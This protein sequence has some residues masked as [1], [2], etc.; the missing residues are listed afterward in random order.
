M[1]RTLLIPISHPDPE[2][3][4]IPSRPDPLASS[5]QEATKL[6]SVLDHFS[7]EALKLAERECVTDQRAL[8]DVEKMYLVST[9]RWSRHL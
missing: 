4:D 7:D 3:C 1:L 8:G 9:D 6:K 2:Y 5:S